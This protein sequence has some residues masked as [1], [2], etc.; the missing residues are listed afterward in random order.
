MAPSERLHVHGGPS[1]ALAASIPA[2][3]ALATGL[4]D[5]ATGTV[6]LPRRRTIPRRG[7]RR[8][9]G[10]PASSPSGDGSASRRAAR[11]DAGPFPQGFPTPAASAPA[12]RRS[13]FPM[14]G[15]EMRAPRSTWRSPI[16]LAGFQVAPRAARLCGGAQLVSRRLTSLVDD[17]LDASHIA[18]G[19]QFSASASAPVEIEALVEDVAELLAPRAHARGLSGS[20]PA[21]RPAY[22]RR[23]RRWRPAPPVLINLVTNSIEATESGA[24]LIAVDQADGPAKT[25]LALT[26]AVH[27]IQPRRR[28]GRSRPHLQLVQR[29]HAD[30]SGL[31]LGLSISQQIIGRVGGRIVLERPRRRRRRTSISRCR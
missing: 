20:A 19:V 4:A 9:S 17:L 3:V 11:D 22:P 7:R 10:T 25:G 31:G 2:V 12:M 1:S 5:P 21:A 18:A 14:V 15:H 29:A 6:A 30:R 27:D 13:R 26:S 23:R 16:S 8:R 24:V 28:W